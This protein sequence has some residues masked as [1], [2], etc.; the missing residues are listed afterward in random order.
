MTTTTALHHEDILTTSRQSREYRLISADS[1][2]NEPGD[3]W[4]KRVPAALRD[5]AP[6]MQ[7]FEQ[8]DAWVIEGVKDPITFG[9]NACAGFEPEQMKGWM[10]FEDVR[11]GGWDPKARIGE[12]ARDNVDAEVL[13]PTTRLSGAIIASQ[14]TAYHLA[15]IRAY[16]DWLSEY[17]AYA[18]DRFAGLMILPNRGGAKETVAEIKRVL[19]RPGMRG[20]MMGTYPNG[21]LT[22]QPEDDAVWGELSDRKIPVSIHIS[23]S[24][25]MPGALKATLPGYNR[26]WDAPNR[27]IEMMFSGVFDRFPDFEV[28]FGEVDF[29]WVPYLREQ[30]DNNYMRL[31]PLNKFGL[32]KPPSAYVDRHFHFG[33]ITDTYGVRNLD[34]MNPERVLWS[35]DYPHIN[36]DYPY[37]WRTI[38]ASLSG[39]PA[40]KR[41]LLLHGNAK[42]LYH[43]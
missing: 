30:M 40:Q 23:L 27:M 10:R 24:Q 12:M 29:G 37:S 9:L 1:H 42:R 25:T 16:N 2:V 41:D 31:E 39:M 5:R 8:G 43:F 34:S 6:K 13:Y 33:Y 38:Q 26:I 22:I 20:V 28:M 21:T 36:A 19:D 14:D 11:K 18:P 7:R 32:K 4:I 35:T 15:M 17:V 3:L